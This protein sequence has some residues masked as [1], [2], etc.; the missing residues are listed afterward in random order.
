MLDWDSVT[1]FNLIIT[2][3]Y[4]HGLPRWL[5]GKESASTAGATGD[6]GSIPRSGRSP[7]EGHGNPL[8]YFCLENPMDK[9][10]WWATVHGVAKSRTRLKRL[11]MHTYISTDF[12]SKHNHSHR[13]WGLQL[14]Y[15]FQGNKM[16]SILTPKPRIFIVVMLVKMSCGMHQKLK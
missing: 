3:L 14:E 6:T 8:Q 9:G 7:G 10:A 16:K 13:Y 4:Q 11:S 2:C 5:S 15:I 1:Q 12:I